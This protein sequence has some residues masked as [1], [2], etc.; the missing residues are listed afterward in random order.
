MSSNHSIMLICTILLAVCE[1]TQGIPRSRRG[2]GDGF[3]FP[4]DSRISS[5][6]SSINSTITSRMDN[7]GE[8]GYGQMVS[9]YYIQ[10]E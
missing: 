2:A 10:I 6:I 1:Y 9:T 5:Q 4:D 8:G 7:N 3:Y